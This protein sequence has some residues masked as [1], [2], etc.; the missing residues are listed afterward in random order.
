MSS[1]GESPIRDTL[2]DHLLDTPTLTRQAPVKVLQSAVEKKKGEV[3][4][5]TTALDVKDVQIALFESDI[6]RN[7]KKVNALFK[8]IT[9]VKSSLN[10][11]ILSFL[12]GLE[13]G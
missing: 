3:R 2:A 10:L 8:K 9:L 5:L 11:L 7:D 13:V 4:E 12:K 6:A 1:G